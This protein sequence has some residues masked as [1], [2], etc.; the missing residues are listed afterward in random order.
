MGDLDQLREREVLFAERMARALAGDA[1]AYRELLQAARVVLEAYVRRILTR[2]GVTDGGAAEDVVQEVLVAVH[3][4]RSTYDPLQPFTPWLFAI[5][6]YK[7]ID[8]LRARRRTGT[9]VALEDL[10]SGAERPCFGAQAD[11]DPFA[12]ADVAR[13]LSELP[14]A[15]RRAVEAIKLHGLSVAEVAAREQVSESALKVA[16]HRAIRRLQK[17]VSEEA[18]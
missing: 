1:G 9:A 16:V 17:R 13:L 5:A 15:T 4:K 12:G 2:A 14:D 6:R 8:S 3:E 7:T 18:S 10:E 11:G